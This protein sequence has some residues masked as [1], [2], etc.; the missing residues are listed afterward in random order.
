M[1]I[2]RKEEGMS[3]Q[4]MSVDAQQAHAQ[5]Q[6]HVYWSKAAFMHAA[7]I[8]GG[9]ISFA[10]MPSKNTHSLRAVSGLVGSQE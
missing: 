9:S 10:G 5:S 6:Q 7:T 2:N 1:L 4:P 3:T 8:T